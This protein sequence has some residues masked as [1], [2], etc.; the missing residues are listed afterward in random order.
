VVEHEPGG[1]AQAARTESGAVSVA[2]KDDQVG[3]R[4]GGD[5]FPFRPPESGHRLGWAAEP[6]LGG[7]EQG[8][9]WAEQGLFR[10]G[11]NVGH[12]PA[13]QTGPCAAMAST[14]SG[15]MTCSSTTAAAGRSRAAST[16]AC[17]VPS[18]SQTTTL[19]CRPFFRNI[20]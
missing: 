3:V 15:S 12:G 10:D 4:A 18:V 20:S 8:V 6:G 16:L 9:L 17:Q 5:D 11:A 19:M 1:M 13:E 7:V 14:L 2:G